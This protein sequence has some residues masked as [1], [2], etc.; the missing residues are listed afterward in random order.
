MKILLVL[1][2][3]AH[4]RVTAKNRGVPR[5]TMLRF[6][7]LPLTTVAA[8]TPPGDPVEIC[9][10]SVCP[11]N[12]D[13]DAEVVGV[14]F[15]TAVAPR[16]Y[17]IAREFRR[18]GKITVAGG[19]HPSFRPEEAAHHFDAVVVGEAE[20]LWP[21]VLSDITSGCLQRI[22]RSSALPDLAAA[23]MP[24]RE[25]TAPWARHYAT[26]HAVQTGRGCRHG[27]RFCSV[28]AFHH[29]TYRHR[30]LDQV[31]AE[32]LRSVPRNFMFI[33]DNI[34]ADTGYARALFA[35][36]VPLKKRWMSQSSLK[37][38]D[39]PEL[40][41]LAK[42]AGCVGLFVG[43]E[44]LS[45]ENLAALNK[46]INNEQDNRLRIRAIHRAGICLQ[47]AVIVG[48]DHDDVRVFRRTLRFLLRERVDALQ[49]SILTPLPGTPLFD[50]FTAAGRMRDLDWSHYDFRHVVFDPA[51]LTAAQLQDGADWLYR[52]FYRL[53]RIA[54]RTLRVLFMAGPVPAIFCWRL[55]MTYRYDN[56]RE[57]II[58]RD[59]A[60]RIFPD[61]S[62]FWQRHWHP[63][64][65]PLSRS[66]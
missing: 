7:I 9:D 28:T 12:F 61:I 11:L 38:A 20:G 48:L 30:P 49:L 59:P 63:R 42:R 29:Q 26:C 51:R 4:L 47:T 1:P 8:L 62:A 50:E 22:Y 36:M 5:R 24:R 33:D 21:Q 55:N 27:C 17:Q 56:R 10:E 52:Q 40:L 54:R 46:T 19:Y 34:I 58:G 44:S 31:L 66:G 16:A 13:G 43:L 2:A 65:A 35:A 3:A 14:S 23:P 32:L 41:T 57:G 53:D 60:R 45:A 18:R 37:I 15:M 64:L 39:D 6:S 25:L